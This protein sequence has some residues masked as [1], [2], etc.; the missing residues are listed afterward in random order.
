[1]IMYKDTKNLSIFLIVTFFGVG[2][3]KFAPGS[4]GS[5]GAFPLQFIANYIC[6]EYFQP[7][8]LL[9]GFL[10]A[11]LITI[12]FC[13]I[14]GWVCVSKY[15]DKGEDKDPKEVVIDEVVGQLITNLG[16]SLGPIF[17]LNS[18]IPLSE[19]YAEVIFAYIVP[20]LL[21]RVFDI[22]KPWPIGWID[23]KFKGAAGVMLD[24]IAASLFAIIINYALVFFL[25]DR[26]I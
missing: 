12:L 23:R 7:E 25:I 18:K 17:V 24:D 3:I 5:L 2:K 10:Y 8:D 11:Q 14:F 13:L 6:L 4:F 20:F 15:I 26:F 22:I 21:F 9:L 16:C 19:K 1:M